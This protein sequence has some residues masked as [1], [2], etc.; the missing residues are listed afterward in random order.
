MTPAELRDRVYQL[1]DQLG[2]TSDEV[3]DRFRA[4]GIRGKRGSECAC[5]LA[6]YLLAANLQGVVDISVDVD[7]VSLELQGQ[8][9]LVD[10]ELPN[11]CAVFV[12]RFDT[13]DIYADLRVE[14]APA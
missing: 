12:T 11:A 1:L 6:V 5:P 10:V 7:S 14:A 13:T 4:L 8:I 2:D 9:D 3:A